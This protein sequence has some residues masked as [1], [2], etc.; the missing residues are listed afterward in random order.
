MF[1]CAV[2]K[3]IGKPLAQST[4]TDTGLPDHLRAPVTII[5]KLFGSFR[6]AD[7]LRNRATEAERQRSKRLR[8]KGVQDKVQY[9]IT[10]QKRIV[11]DTIADLGRLG[12]HNHRAKPRLPGSNIRVE[13]AEKGPGGR[14]RVRF[15]DYADKNHHHH[16]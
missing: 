4:S 1:R 7:A 3:E 8:A 10:E 16:G 15:C 2:E 13:F 11:R 6:N 5:K 14:W 12:I 9:T